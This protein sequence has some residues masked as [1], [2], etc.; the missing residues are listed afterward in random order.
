MRKSVKIMTDHSSVVSGLKCLLFETAMNLYCN[1]SEDYFNVDAKPFVPAAKPQHSA[2]GSNTATAVTESQKLLN[3]GLNSK[4][5]K[6][7]DEAKES[8]AADAAGANIPE[9]DQVQQN[10]DKKR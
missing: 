7:N 10:L 8:A 1:L 5:P 4:V 3:F 9:K 2:G 6:P